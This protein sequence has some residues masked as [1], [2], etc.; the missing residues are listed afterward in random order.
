MA[1]VEFKIFDK[2]KVK[3]YFRLLEEAGADYD[4]I[5][6]IACDENMKT[7][8]GGYVLGINKNTG[9]FF[10]C[11]CCDV[12]GLALDEKGRILEEGE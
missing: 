6:L 7:L 1:E 9:K 8:S 11:S 12:P 2:P 4:D 5:Y 10:R 3:V